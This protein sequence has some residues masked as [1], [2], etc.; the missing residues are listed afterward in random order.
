MEHQYQLVF[1][2]AADRCDLDAYLELEQK[3]MHGLSSHPEIVVDGH[4]FG[5]GEFNIFIHTNT[6]LETFETTGD[7]LGSL[8]P[9]LPFSAGYRQF[10][11]DEYKPLWPRNATSFRV[12]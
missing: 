11:E 7:L 9:K 2:F 5:I 3:V 12:A 6:P 8:C 4:D 1:Q 10:G